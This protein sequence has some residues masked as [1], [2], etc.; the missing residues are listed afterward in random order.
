MPEPDHQNLAGTARAFGL[1]DSRDTRLLTATASASAVRL[2][3]FGP[4]SLVSL[5]LA[6]ARTGWRGEALL[7]ATAARASAKAQQP[8]PQGLGNLVWSMATPL[9][10]HEPSLEVW[11]FEART[12]ARR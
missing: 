3:D 11:A 4:L 10:P 1:P 5:A 8:S 9:V 12:R 6:S 7:Q 2:E